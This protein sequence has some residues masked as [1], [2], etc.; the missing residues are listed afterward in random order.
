MIRPPGPW[1]EWGAREDLPAE[2]GRVRAERPPRAR[3]RANLLFLDGTPADELPHRDVS[4]IPH[5][6][7][8]DT[9]E[10]LKGTGAALWFIHVNH[11]NREWD[12]GDVAREGMDFPL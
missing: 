1:N 5:P 12:A 10:R 8:S 11:T 3:A 9:R 6:L 4:R 7:M 2:T